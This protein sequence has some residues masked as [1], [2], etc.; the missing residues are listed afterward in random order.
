MGSR[1]LL[2][3]LIV[4]TISVGVLFAAACSTS[5]SKPE[6]TVAAA[7][8]LRVAFDELAPIYERN[9][10]CKVTLTYGSSGTFATQIKEGLPADVFASANVSYVDDLDA[11]GLIVS[12]TK[13]PYAVGRIVVAF[14]ATTARDPSGLTDLVGPDIRRVSIANPDHAPYGVAAKEA[15]IATGL[16]EQVQPNLVLGENAAQATQFVE[17]GDAQGGIVPLSLAVQ[18]K[19]GLKYKLI[20]D[21]LHTPLKQVGAVLKHSKHAAIAAGFLKFINSPE[22]RTVMKKYGFVLPGEAAP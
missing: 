6:I 10:D 20:D 13:Q 1:A 16:W 18:N 3:A 14:P 9:C 8:D 17:T 12:D 21:A 4:A 7:A 19:N 15:L 11:A 5:G 2:S 22:G